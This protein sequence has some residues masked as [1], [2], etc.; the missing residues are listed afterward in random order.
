MVKTD[1]RST[2][3]LLK[4]QRDALKH[5]LD[6]QNKWSLKPTAIGLALLG[7]AVLLLWFLTNDNTT[8][9]MLLALTGISLLAIAILM[10]FFS[11]S[12]YLRSE[13]CEA[14]AISDTLTIR[15]ILA[16][17]LVDTRG[18]YV[19]ASQ[20]GTTKIFIPLKELTAEEAGTVSPGSEQVF[21]VTDKSSKGIVIHPPGHGL[22]LYVQRVG[23]LFTEEGLENE[24]R[25]VL[26]NSLEI[27]SDVSVKIEGGKAYVNM[28][29][30]ALAGMC[31]SIR[32]EDPGICLQMGCPLCS[33]VGCMIV[34]GTGKKARI[35]NVGV[36]GR[37]IS[38]VFELLGD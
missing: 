15:K 20:A 32:A 3:I 2:M 24:I 16:S 18:I 17:L 29:K 21:N 14:L 6:R 13:V 33:L 5:R 22:F 9:S 34:D 12:R 37:T 4:D 35:E 38:I 27:A 11:P 1:Q 8:M 31:K 30:I 7:A 26:V 36:E 19:P 28:S 25:D 23:A 10:F